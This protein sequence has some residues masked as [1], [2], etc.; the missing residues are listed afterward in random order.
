MVVRILDI[1]TGADTSDQGAVVLSRL[2]AEL[3]QG[4]PVVVSFEGVNTA[5]SSFVAASFVPLLEQYKLHEV[6]QRLRVI[7][8]TRQINSMIKA[9]LERE[10]LA[11]A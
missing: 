6:K 11:P 1:V 4:A 2:R 9:R 7:N 10:A 5:T 3:K 8:S